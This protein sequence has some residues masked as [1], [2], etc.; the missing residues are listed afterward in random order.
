MLCRFAFSSFGVCLW[1]D[2]DQP[3]IICIRDVSA[4]LPKDTD[5]LYTKNS[6]LLVSPSSI[7]RVTPIPPC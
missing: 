7:Y 1:Y 5:E 2:G 6:C 4:K 3:R